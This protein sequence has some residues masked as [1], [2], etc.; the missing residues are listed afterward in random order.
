MPQ[1]YQHNLSL[2]EKVSKEEVVIVLKDE[3]MED[4]DF[5]KTD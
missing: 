3:R 5:G 1:I 4:V 2:A